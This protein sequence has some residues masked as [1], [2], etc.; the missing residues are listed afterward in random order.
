MF[1]QIRNKIISNFRDI[2]IW[3]SCIESNQNSSG[4][5]AQGISDYQAISFG[6]FFVYTYGVYEEIIRNIILET[7]NQLNNST[8]LISQCI[9]ELYS[10]LLSPEYDSLYNVGNEHKWEKRWDIS[11][12]LSNDSQI[13]IPS[14]L[15]PTDGKNIKIRQ[16]ESIRK[17]FGISGEMLPRPEIGWY[18]NEMVENR[19]SIAHG[20][21]LPKEVGRS[22]TK[23]DLITRCEIISEICIYIC[24]LFE[25][26]IEKKEYIKK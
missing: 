18:V 2:K 5:V 22:Y 10:L 8:V 20:N 13:V 4:I 26:Y 21:K 11:E 9:F 17:S 3:I 19:N 7:I 16:L 23:E 1:D 25:K 24:D 6:L 15:F 14:V 12:K